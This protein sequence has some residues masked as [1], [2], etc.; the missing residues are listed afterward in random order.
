MK[1]ETKTDIIKMI[2]QFILA[3]TLFWIAIYQKSTPIIGNV[4]APIGEAGKKFGISF[5]FSM[6]IVFSIIGVVGLII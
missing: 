6:I 4:I 2:Y 5:W 3:G 1:K